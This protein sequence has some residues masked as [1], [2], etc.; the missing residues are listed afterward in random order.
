MQREYANR[1][2]NK[3]KK[4]PPARASVFSAIILFRFNPTALQV[5]SMF[6]LNK[7]PCY[8]YCR[9]I[10]NREKTMRCEVHTR[11][12]FRSRCLV[13]VYREAVVKLSRWRDIQRREQ[14]REKEKK[15]EG[16]REKKTILKNLARQ[17]NESSTLILHC[18]VLGLY[19]W[20]YVR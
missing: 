10:D 8:S 1:Y 13:A 2:C 15:K 5:N 16:K 3:N 17:G 20:L 18:I 14:L 4:V 11:V 19:V 6:T 12:T 7:I 9:T